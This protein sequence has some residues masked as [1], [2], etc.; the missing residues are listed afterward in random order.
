MPKKIT[1]EEYRLPPTP[2][3]IDRINDYAFK[4]GLERKNGAFYDRN[5]RFAGNMYSIGKEAGID[6][7]ECK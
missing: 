5:G 4:A 6:M 1:I 7:Q 3:V 2:S